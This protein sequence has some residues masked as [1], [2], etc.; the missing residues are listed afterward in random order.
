MFPPLPCLA[1]VDHDT[2]LLSLQCLPII[3]IIKFGSLAE[4]QDISCSGLSLLA[5]YSFILSLITPWHWNFLPET[6]NYFH[7]FIHTPCYFVSQSSVSSFHLSHLGNSQSRC[8]FLQKTFPQTRSKANISFPSPQR[9]QTISMLPLSLIGSISE[10]AK[11]PT[12]Q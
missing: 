6:L 3:F 4:I 12:T 10:H 11:L 7:F 8:H 9:P 5:F 2:F 1:L